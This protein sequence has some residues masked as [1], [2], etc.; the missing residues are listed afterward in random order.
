M[1]RLERSPDNKSLSYSSYTFGDPATPM[2]ARLPGRPD[3]VPDPARRQ[4]D[5]PRLPHARRRHPL[6][7]QPRSRPHLRLRRHRPD[8]HPKEQHLVAPGLAVLRAPASRTTCE[9]EGGAGGVQ[10]TA[11]TCSSTATSPSTTSRACGRSGGCTTPASPTSRPCPTA[12][13]RRSRSTRAASSAARWPTA[14]SSRRTTSTTGSSRSCRRRACRATAQDAE[15]WNWRIDTQR[16]RRA[17]C[18][19]GEPEEDEAWPTCPASSRATPRRSRRPLRRQPA[20]DPVQ[21]GQRPARLPAAAPAHRPAVAARAQRALRR[22][23][24]RRDDADARSPRARRTRSPTARTGS[25]PPARRRGR[26]TST[27]IELP[28]QVTTQAR[29]P[30]RQ[31]LRPQQGQG[32]RPRRPQG[33]GAARDPRQHRRLHPAHALHRARAG[34]RSAPLL[35]GPTCTSTTCS[36][37]S[38]AP[39]APAPAWSST[40]RSCPTSSWTRA[41]RGAAAGASTIQLTERGEVPPARRRHRRRRG[42]GDHRGPPDRPRSTEPRGR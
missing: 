25:A 31:D 34:G 11:A 8:K 15:V 39:T 42:H 13:P 2:P 6:A 29:G 20:R 30:H 21:P 5:V 27:T 3:Q 33:A 26:S 38:R 18:Y 7:V 14:P 22:A 40:S 17:R 28:I 16:P 12:P 4:R 19:L 9:I 1:H 35:H 23:V 37:T 32:R 10:Q 41:R 24:P 36:S